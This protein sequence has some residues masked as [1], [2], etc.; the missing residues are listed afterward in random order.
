MSNNKI[1]LIYVMIV[2]VAMIPIALVLES[3]TSGAGWP[4][5][6]GVVGGVAVFTMLFALADRYY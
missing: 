2:S 6:L 3:H 1:R 4:S 5:Y